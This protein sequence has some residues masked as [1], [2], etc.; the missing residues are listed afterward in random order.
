MALHIMEDGY[1][2]LCGRQWAHV[3]D[4]GA[5]HIRLNAVTAKDYRSKGEWS[6]DRPCGTCGFALLSR[7]HR[8]QFVK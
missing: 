5:I 8:M 1:Q 4:A 7:D 3:D 6:R 2:T